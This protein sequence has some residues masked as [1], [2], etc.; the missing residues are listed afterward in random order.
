MTF[1]LNGMSVIP[2]QAR[3]RTIYEYFLARIAVFFN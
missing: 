1:I 3:I 2:A